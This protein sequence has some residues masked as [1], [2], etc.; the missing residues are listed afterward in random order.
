I[1]LPIEDRINDVKVV[2]DE[3]MDKNPDRFWL[4][5]QQDGDRTQEMV[6]YL[7]YS[8]SVFFVVHAQT[9]QLKALRMLAHD[10][11][12]KEGC[13]VVPEAILDR[14][15]IVSEEIFEIKTDYPKGILYEIVLD[16]P[17]LTHVVI[18]NLLEDFFMRNGTPPMAKRI[19]PVTL[20]KRLIDAQNQGYLT[21]EYTLTPL[22]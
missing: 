19:N 18:D 17:G 15:S 21:T 4:C 9:A 1:D 2:V 16:V 5:A 8:E 14:V 12:Y 7:P 22:L 6:I 10:F 13:A 3:L 11:G 20:A